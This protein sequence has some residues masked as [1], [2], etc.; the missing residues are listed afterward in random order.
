MK[1]ESERILWADD[2]IKQSLEVEHQESV[3]VNHVD[4]RG[5]SVV[6]EP[7]GMG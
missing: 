1:L 3:I 7:I 2:L 5:S 4:S 6:M